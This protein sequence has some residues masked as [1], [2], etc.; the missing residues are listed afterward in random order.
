MCMRVCAR[1]DPAARIQDESSRASFR[2]KTNDLDVPPSA[3]VT[4]DSRRVATR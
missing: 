3:N 4:D 1:D 2:W